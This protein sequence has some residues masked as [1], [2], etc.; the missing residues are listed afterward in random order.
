MTAKL[1][2]VTDAAPDNGAEI[3]GNDARRR[4][5]TQA[6]SP[7]TL[8][9]AWVP[10]DDGG[11]GHYRIIDPA[12][13]IAE[14]EQAECL[15]AE[16]EGELASCDVV[17]FQRVYSPRNLDLIVRLR[18]R[19]CLVVYDLD[20]A[21]W[22]LDGSLLNPAVPLFMQAERLECLVDCLQHADLATVTTP[23]L[24]E[25]VRRWQPH[26]E[27]LP[28]R[29][30]VAAWDEAR[31][32]NRRFARGDAEV[33]IGWAGSATHERDWRMVAAPLAE[34]DAKFK[35]RLLWRLLGS[36]DD[37]WRWSGV[38][39]NNRV[40][41]YPWVSFDKYPAA[42]WSLGLDIGLCPLWPHQFNAQ[43]SPI[44]AWEYALAGAAVVASDFGPYSTLS[45]E[46]AVLA[47]TPEEW[48]P[49]LSGLIEGAGNR[50]R[51]QESLER[52]VRRDHALE[53]MGGSW[54]AVFWKHLTRIR[55]QEERFL[56]HSRKWASP[57]RPGVVSR[58]AMVERRVRG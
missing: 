57:Y 28:N 19:G 43:K 51:M 14:S 41:V 20:D 26:V 39:P 33:V 17:V 6:T 21:V 35:G 53:G 54:V 23:V 58:L 38:L 52:T 50:R 11:C 8:R 56:Y 40:E 42:L 16:A 5:V 47:K 7:E 24:A 32:A 18:R 45:P 55:E 46:D 9:I 44:K 36:P 37:L 48:V 13:E 27:V 15:L 49:A 34:I 31:A 2:L 22:D 1:R 12:R 3:E 30:W 10:S 25:S 4:P 29:L